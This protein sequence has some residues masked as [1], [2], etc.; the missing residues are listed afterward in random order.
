MGVESMTEHTDS[1]EAPVLVNI[2]DAIATITLNDPKRLNPLGQ[3]L[4]RG[5]DAAIQSVKIDPSVRVIIITGAGRGFS[6]GGDTSSLRRSAEEGRQEPAGGEAADSSRWLDNSYP[7]LFR[8]I[9]K[10][11]IGAINGVAVGAGFGL[12]LACDLRIAAEDARMG[13][14]WPRLGLAAEHGSSLLLTRMI[15]LPRAMDLMLTGRFVTGREAYEM[16]MVNQAVP[17]EKVLAA[18]REMANELVKSAPLAV[19]ALKQQV[20]A[21]LESTLEQQILREH[22]AM[23]ELMRS[24]DHREGMRAAFEERP[25]RFQGL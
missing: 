5:F 18:A 8:S 13:T 15:G 1:V 24:Q 12:A 14:R 4:R 7:A 25:P 10:P 3:A 23:R 22:D 16:G 17:K 9:P 2:S 11:V 20:Y 21:G 19:A 6:S